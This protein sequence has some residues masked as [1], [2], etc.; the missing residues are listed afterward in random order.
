MQLLLDDS[1][2]KTV[3]LDRIILFL[4]LFLLFVPKFIKIVSPTSSVDEAMVKRNAQHP[5]VRQ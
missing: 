5:S 3:N 1:N 2:L 4:V